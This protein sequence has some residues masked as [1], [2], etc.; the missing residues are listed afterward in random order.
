MIHQ[1]HG[2]DRDSGIGM[3]NDV[4]TVGELEFVNGQVDVYRR[5]VAIS[6]FVDRKATIAFY[7]E[8][9]FLR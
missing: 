3:Q 7:S 2:H 9:V 4:E 6:A 8:Q 1:F 5:H